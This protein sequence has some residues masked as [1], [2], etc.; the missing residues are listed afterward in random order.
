M[1]M[2]CKRPDPRMKSTSLTPLRTA[3]LALL[4][5]LTGCVNLAPPYQ[6]PVVDTPIAFKEGSGAWVPGAPADALD[7][8]D[9]WTLFDDPVLNDLA[10]QVD[11]SNQNVAAAV[12]A[13]AQARAITRE[14]RAGLFPQ[15]NLNSNRNAS[16]GPDRSTIRSYQVNIGASWEPDVFGRLRLAVESA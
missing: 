10:S 1:A 12:A 3:S 9:W 16:G 4:I 2:S 8:G 5:L 14:Q 11:F 13:Y 7:R 15:V 6:V